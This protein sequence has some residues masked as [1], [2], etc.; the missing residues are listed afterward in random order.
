MKN[1][2]HT[3]IDFSNYFVIYDCNLIKQNNYT[4]LRKVK[5]IY[6][7]DNFLNVAYDNEFNNDKEIYIEDVDGITHYSVVFLIVNKN[8]IPKDLNNFYHLDAQN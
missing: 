7:T 3:L 8:Y 4:V 2:A 5:N 6:V 1:P